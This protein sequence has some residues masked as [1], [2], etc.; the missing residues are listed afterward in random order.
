[1]WTG[2]CLERKHAGKK[3]HEY[4]QQYWFFHNDLL[5]RG[6]VAAGYLRTYRKTE[7]LAPPSENCS[8]CGI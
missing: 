4:Y 6:A 7:A 8:D 1:L 5:V 3:N 2:K